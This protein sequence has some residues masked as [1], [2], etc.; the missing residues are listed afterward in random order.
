[1][2]HSIGLK[3]INL[4]FMRCFVHSPIRTYYKIRNSFILLRKNHVPL[5]MALKEI[6]TILIHQFV[7]L[8]FVKN[9]IE[10]IKNYYAAVI[11][12]VKGT[13]GQKPLNK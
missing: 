12:G 1:M 9:K 4:W 8:F 2:I 11:H 13:V 3:S 5:L 10:Y 6:I 7:L